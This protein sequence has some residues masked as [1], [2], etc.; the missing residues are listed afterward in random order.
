MPMEVAPQA[1]EIP[2]PLSNYEEVLRGRA[3]R[4]LAGWESAIRTARAATAA[5][6][7]DVGVVFHRGF[8]AT[9]RVGDRASRVVARVPP[10][11]EPVLTL[12][13]REI[14]VRAAASIAVLRWC[15]ARYGEDTVARVT[16]LAHGPA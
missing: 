13:G 12:R 10:W 15:V 9:V 4:A 16:K 7:L 14:A 6:E 8:S 3:E 2:S 11:L 5:F 1:W